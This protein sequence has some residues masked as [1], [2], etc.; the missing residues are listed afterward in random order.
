MAYHY[1]PKLSTKVVDT[2]LL[3]RIDG[4]IDVCKDVMDYTIPSVSS[5]QDLE[6]FDLIRTIDSLMKLC[7]VIW[8]KFDLANLCSF[9]SIRRFH[10]NA[11]CQKLEP[12]NY[13][14]YKPLL[15]S[16]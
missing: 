10:F 3:Q 6:S 8:R 4:I 11:V 9:M 1:L 2:E 15:E 7:E 14:A 12:D 13:V 16:S 5:I